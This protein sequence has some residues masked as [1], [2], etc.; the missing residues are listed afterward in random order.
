MSTAATLGAA[1]QLI[2]QN[3]S[4]VFALMRTVTQ[5]MMQPA[6][7]LVRVGLTT[8]LRSAHERA[9]QLA[10][11]L[12]QNHREYIYIYVEIIKILVKSS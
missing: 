3:I 2:I 6:F 8:R 4:R 10:S 5:R 7:S 12:G 9:S 1:G 11:L